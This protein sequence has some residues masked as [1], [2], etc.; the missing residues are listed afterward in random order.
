M[1]MGLVGMFMITVLLF[2]AGRGPLVIWATVSLAII[3]VT[4]GLLLPVL[5]T[6]LHRIK[7]QP[8]AELD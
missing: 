6:M 4:L 5:Y 3:G 1:T 7:H 2:K 8:L